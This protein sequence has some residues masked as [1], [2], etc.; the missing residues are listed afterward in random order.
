MLYEHKIPFEL[1]VFP[2][3]QHGLGLAP[4]NPHVAQWAPLLVNWLKLYKY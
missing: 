1:H 4:G 3:G 2:F